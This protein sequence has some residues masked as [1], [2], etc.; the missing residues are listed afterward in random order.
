MENAQKKAHACAN[1]DGQAENAKRAHKQTLEII[2][3]RQSSRQCSS[4][5]SSWVQDTGITR[6]Q[7]P[8]RKQTWLLK[9][10]FDPLAA[11]AP[12]T[13]E[14]SDQHK[15]PMGRRQT[16]LILSIRRLRRDS[17]P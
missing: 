15:R 8:A 10:L 13:E 4:P 3:R 12:V 7:D 11:D 1:E 9:S 17:K 6:T 14:D 2:M 5:S 16:P